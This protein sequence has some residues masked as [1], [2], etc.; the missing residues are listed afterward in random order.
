MHHA[1]TKGVQRSATDDML[2]LMSPGMGSGMGVLLRRQ[3]DDRGLLRAMLMTRTVPSRNS[4]RALPFR[5]L[6][7]AE[8]AAPWAALWRQWKQR[9]RR[10]APAGD[11]KASE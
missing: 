5:A 3:G 8:M 11:Q 2:L 1:H 10:P 9:Q 6:C 7:S 4:T